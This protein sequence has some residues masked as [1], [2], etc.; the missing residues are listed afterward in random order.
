MQSRSIDDWE[1]A[2]A[3]TPIIRWAGRT[4]RAHNQR[5]V[6]TDHG[7]SLK[8]TGRYHRGLDTAPIEAAWPALY[9]ALAPEICLAEILRHVTPESLARLN[10]QRLSEVIVSMAAVLDLRNPGTL[11]ISP[12]QLIHDVD[13]RVTQRIAE[14]AVRSR[15]EGLI[16]PSATNLGDNLIVFPNNLRDSSSLAVVSSREP[17]LYVDRT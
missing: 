3:T 8:A 10:H 15:F 17:R 6:A 9:L 12:N 1:T 13:Y 16:V 5:Y 7:G 2:I 11:G 4:W 14:I